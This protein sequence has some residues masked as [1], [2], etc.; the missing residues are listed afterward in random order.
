MGGRHQTII[1]DDDDEEEEEEED[2]D[3][4][5]YMYLADMHPDKRDQYREAIRVSKANKW[6]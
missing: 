2:G 6:N 5:V 4:D 1:D 3:K